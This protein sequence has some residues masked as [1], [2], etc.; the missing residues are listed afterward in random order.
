MSE[1]ILLIEND[2][3]ILT[4]QA[5][6]NLF[7]HFYNSHKKS[8]LFCWFKFMF[9]ENIGIILFDENIGIVLFDE[10]TEIVHIV[11]MKVIFTALI[12]YKIRRYKIMKLVKSK[13]ILLIEKMIE[14]FLHYRWKV[15]YWFVFITHTK[16]NNFLNS[17]QIPILWEHWYRI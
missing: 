2:W 8:N 10:N 13:F 12:L 17:F 4:L 3:K 9:D 1:F 6:M 5:K 11:W 14:K 16:K 15:I 7:I